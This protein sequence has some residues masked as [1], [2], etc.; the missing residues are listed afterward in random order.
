MRLLALRGHE[1]AILQRSASRSR[2][3]AADAGQRRDSDFF[4]APCARRGPAGNFCRPRDI[5]AIHTHN[6]SA[7]AFGAVLRL[8]YRVPC[9]ATALHCPQQGIDAVHARSEPRAAPQAA[10][11]AAFIDQSHLEGAAEGPWTPDAG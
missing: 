11:G 6:S 10:R 2:L 5:H 8:F 3:D 1:I 9:V 7:D 4:L